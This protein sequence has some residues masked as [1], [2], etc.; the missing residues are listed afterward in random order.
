MTFRTHLAKRLPLQTRIN[1]SVCLPIVCIYLPNFLSNHKYHANPISNATKAHVAPVPLRRGMLLT[2][3]FT[4]AVKPYGTA[5][6]P[7]TL[8]GYQCPRPP[9]QPAASPDHIRIPQLS[10]VEECC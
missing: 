2:R 10:P 7:S 9:S 5:Y 8:P 3:T 6:G 4:Q 1:I